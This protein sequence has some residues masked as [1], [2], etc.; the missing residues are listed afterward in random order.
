MTLLEYLQ[1]TWY[2]PQDTVPGQGDWYDLQRGDGMIRVV[3]RDGDT[4]IHRFDQYMVCEWSAHFSNGTPDDV[5]TA[6]LK[7][8]ESE[9]Q[10]RITI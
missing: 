7:T 3:T 1:A 8:A 5:I 6:A 4:H 2:D 10:E 9:L